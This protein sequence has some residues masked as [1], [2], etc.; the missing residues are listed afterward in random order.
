MATRIVK[1]TDLGV[2]VGLSAGI[3]ITN[4]D[5]ETLLIESR[6][7]DRERAWEVIKL[8]RAL[9]YEM[10][11]VEFIPGVRSVSSDEYAVQQA[12]LEAGLIPDPYEIGSAIDAYYKEINK[13]G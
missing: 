9:G 13:S 10:V 4:D 11:T 7:G 1:E 8:A 5:G 2:Y 6:E 12:R 3:P